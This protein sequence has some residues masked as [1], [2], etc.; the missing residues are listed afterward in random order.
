MKCNHSILLST[1]LLASPRAGDT[2]A[3]A[4]FRVTHHRGPFLK[5]PTTHPRRVAAERASVPIEPCDP[6]EGSTIHR[7]GRARK[8]TTT[9]GFRAGSHGGEASGSKRWQS[10]API[11]GASLSKEARG[12]APGGAPP[13]RG[14]KH[15]T[16]RAV[17][18]H[19]L[20][21]A[22]ATSDRSWPSERGNLPP[23]GRFDV[24]S[25]LWPSAGGDCEAF[26]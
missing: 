6:Q 16:G 11:D 26:E 22:P 20:V 18:P 10:G 12:E 1:R 13:R 2:G 23:L 17:H 8:T 5:G 19:Q 24:S 7:T 9:S 15:R 3:N 4:P 25:Q 21:N 14:W